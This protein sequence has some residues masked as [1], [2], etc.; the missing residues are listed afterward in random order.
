M[1]F[2][3][4]LKKIFSK[5]PKIVTISNEI[6]KNLNADPNASQIVKTLQRKGYEAYLVGGCIRDALINIIPKDF[7]IATEAKPEEVKK[8]IRS[9]RIIG[10]RFRLVHAYMGRQIYE[11]ATFRNSST[12]KEHH[13]KVHSKSD[14][15]RILRD[16]IY[17]NKIQDAARRDF[18]VNALYYDPTEQNIT[19]YYN[20]ILCIW[21]R[22]QIN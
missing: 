6:A 13:P 10:K 18:T 4:L 5:K 17:G 7:D 12:N 14:S 19:D 21:G 15:G 11:V 22:P 16:N 3:Y 9:S 8:A 20:G 2:I 1:T